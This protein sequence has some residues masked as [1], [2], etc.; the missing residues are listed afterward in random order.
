MSER[1]EAFLREKSPPTPFLVVDLKIVRAR[2]TELRQALP[3]AEIFYAVKA[4]PASEVVAALAQLGANFDLASPGEITICRELAIEPGR[5]SFGNTVKRESAIAEAARDGIRLF[6]FDSDAELRKLACRAPRARVFCRL[7]IENAGAEWPLS[8]KFGCDAHLAA[9][10]LVAAKGL[11]LHPSGVSFH[12]GSQQTEPQ[13]WA[14][15]I[16]HAAW[17]FHACRRRGIEL[18]LLNLGGG[19]PAHYR[20][21]VPPLAD[22]AEAIET[23]LKTHFGG[24]GP[25]VLIEPGRY[26]VGDAGLL[27]TEIL[28]ISRKSANEQERW[29]YLDAGIY[30]GL[31]ETLDERIHYPIRTARDGGPCGPVILAGPT[32][33]SADILYRRHPYELPL[34]LEIGEPVDFL[35]AGAYTASAAAVA[36]NGF[37]PIRSYYV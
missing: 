1:I 21:P 14:H 4:N 34:D 11:G 31:A 22:Y 15:A 20:A 33:D 9:D 19:L 8:R 23:A 26:L 25:R 30:N 13:A 16:G 36:F 7:L 24:S 32:C 35:S 10:L 27:R 18:E 37:A 2:Y 5:L 29:I 6:A 3:N 17:V 12:V 28:L